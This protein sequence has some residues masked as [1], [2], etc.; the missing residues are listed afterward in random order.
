M[1]KKIIP[2]IVQNQRI[3]ELTEESTAYEAAKQMMDCNV[4]AVVVINEEGALTGIMTERDVT[5]RVIARDL[6]PRKT[7][8]R[9][10]MTREPDTLAPGDSA[11]NALELMRTRGYRHLPVIDTGKVVGMVSIRDLYEVAKEDLEHGIRET[12]AYVFGDRYGA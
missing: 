9:D 12:E 3:C 2:H 7:K 8:L 1:D 10:I 6:D 5:R 4:A 11:V